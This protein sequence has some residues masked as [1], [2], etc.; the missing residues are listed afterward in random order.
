MS[1]FSIQTLARPLFVRGT[2]PDD[3]AFAGQV[4][5]LGWWPTE[6]SS[7]RS[8]SRS[9][10]TRRAPELSYLVSDPARPAPFWVSERML[11]E[12]LPYAG[13]DPRGRSV[14]SDPPTTA[15]AP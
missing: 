12:Q 8:T 1:D 11:T 2:T 7:G 3:V 15:N 10:H 5:A 13:R 14:L 6:A 9:R 4:L